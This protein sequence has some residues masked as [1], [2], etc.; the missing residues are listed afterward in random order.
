VAIPGGGAGDVQVFWA[1]ELLLTARGH[2]RVAL[3]LAG[4]ET[5]RAVITAP[6]G[7]R[8]EENLAP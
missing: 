3:R 8:R 4:G 5:Y 1:D 6:D 2:E 7:T